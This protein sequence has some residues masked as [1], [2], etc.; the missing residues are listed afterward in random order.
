MA[1]TCDGVLSD[2]ANP[3]RGQS[4][5]PE[6]SQQKVGSLAIVDVVGNM[7]A[8]IWALFSKIGFGDDQNAR[9]SIEDR[10][11]LELAKEFMNLKVTR[12]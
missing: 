6:L 10:I 12:I 11:T 5:Q 2:V 9:L 4:F 7:R 8:K 1:R 3:L